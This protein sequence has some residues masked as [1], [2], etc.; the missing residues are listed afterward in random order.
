MELLP[1]GLRFSAQ[2][3]A[4]FSRNSFRVDPTS[5]STVL[6]GGQITFNLPEG[7]VLD[8]KSLAMYARVKTLSGLADEVVGKLPSD[9]PNS[10]ISR[11][12]VLLNGVD[13]LSGLTDYATAYN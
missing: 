6:S 12:E 2:R 1:K 9:S 4:D 7:C 10:L 13:L 11:M 5:N 8:L 3:M